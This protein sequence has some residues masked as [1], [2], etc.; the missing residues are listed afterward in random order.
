MQCAV[1]FEGETPAIQELFN[2]RPF[3]YPTGPIWFVDLPQT[4]AGKRWSR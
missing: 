1:S 2:V 3:Y 4:E